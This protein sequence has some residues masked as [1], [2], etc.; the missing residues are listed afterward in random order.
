MGIIVLVAI[1]QFDGPIR[2][3]QFWGDASYGG[4][5][6]DVIYVII[7]LGKIGGSQDLAEAKLS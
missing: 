4:P 5:V 1:Q 7:D 3:D 2:L 6:H